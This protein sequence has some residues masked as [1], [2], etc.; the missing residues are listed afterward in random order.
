MDNCIVQSTWRGQDEHQHS[1]ITGS[2]RGLQSLS[3]IHPMSPCPHNVR[4]HDNSLLHQQGRARAIPLCT[5]HRPVE[6]V[7]QELIQPVSSLSSR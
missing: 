1:E 6:L 7:H 4:Q 2:M 3:S 5:S